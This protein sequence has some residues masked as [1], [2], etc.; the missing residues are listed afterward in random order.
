[1]RVFRIISFILIV[2]LLLCCKK[3]STKPDD[4][5]PHY[6]PRYTDMEPAWSQDG[7]TI[8][9]VHGGID[10]EGD[11]TGI[12]LI[13]VDGTDNRL[14]YRGT[15]AYGPDFSPDGNWLAFDNY[16][17]IFKIKLNGD[18]LTQL[19]FG[20][21]N[22]FP[23]WSPDGKKIAY[24]VTEPIDT[25]GIY[26][27]QEDGTFPHLVPG[28]YGG[29]FPDFSP[30]GKKLLCL[31]SYNN[32]GKVE[33][34]FWIISLEDA[35]HIRLPLFRGDNRYPVFSPDGKKIAFSSMYYSAP[36]IY[37]MDADGKNLKL[38]TPE[39][40]DMQAWSPDGTKI[41]YVKEANKHSSE[42]GQIWIMDADGS[43][44]RQLTF[45]GW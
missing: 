30:D 18:S 37:V 16:A 32:A 34:Y 25:G 7:K 28:G 14:L 9:Y 23:D 29:R 44:K 24:D 40:G 5:L 31:I 42:D 19:T 1:M 22:F 27:M 45:N 2:L 13:D 43:N 41:A 38:L 17:Q 3:K 33:D 11:T 39:G 10:E 20:G 12:Y 15:K 21:R 26:L 35:N 36:V 6:W 8:A 4:G